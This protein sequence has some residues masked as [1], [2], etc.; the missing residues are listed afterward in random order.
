MTE[1]APELDVLIIGGGQAGL[2]MGFH[3]RET[4]F[5]FRIVERHARVGDSWRNRYASLVLFT[6]R[7]YSALPGLAVPGDPEGY[8]TK[9][10]MAD[11]LESYSERFDLPVAPGTGIGRLERVDG[12]FRAT[13]EAGEPID[14]RA[15]VLATGA[16]QRPAIPPVSKRLSSEVTQL[17]P[18]DYRTPGQLAAGRVLVVGD[19][20][21]GRQIA[22]ELTD[23]HGVLLAAGRP[24]RVSPERI[25]GR[26][27]F[28]WMDK[29]GILTASRESRIGRFV[30]EADPFPGKRLELDKLQQRGVEVVGRVAQAEGKK[31]SFADGKTAEVDAVVWAT[32]YRDDTGWV[33]IPEVKDSQGNFMHYRG[34]SPL[35]NLCFVGRSWQWTRGSAL[36]AGVGEDAAYLAEHIVG[37]LDY[38]AAA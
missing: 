7:A 20:A 28:W 3:L 23:N 25:L 5:S 9:D 18:E 13:T 27:V 10:E 21:T 36:F 26:S 11:Y 19:G 12:G 38:R 17:A 37:H 22:L 6:P 15:V 16:F 29:L 4:P 14:S 32:G 33:A 31:V 30:M 2:A 34:I 24:R 35:P 1:N 8:P